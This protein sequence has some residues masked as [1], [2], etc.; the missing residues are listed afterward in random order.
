MELYWQ[1][2]LGQY[3]GEFQSDEGMQFIWMEEEDS[4]EK[5]MEL[6]RQ[7]D[8]AGGLLEAGLEDEAA[9]DSIRWEETGTENE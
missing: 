4:L 9:W 2:E 1:E 8:L 5:K 3:Y 7:Y 6:I